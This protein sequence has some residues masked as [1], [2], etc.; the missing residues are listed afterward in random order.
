MTTPTNIVLTESKDMLIV[1][2][3]QEAEH[4]LPAEY[5]RVFS[6]SAEVR[7]HGKGQ[8][9]LQYGKRQV[10]IQ[11]IQQAGNYAIQIT[12]NDGHDSGIFT[13]D[14]LYELGE[15][16]TDNWIS[17]LGRLHE[18]GQSREAGVQVVNLT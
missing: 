17:Y 6:P 12:F 13:W 15:G 16:Y 3:D 2:Y 5:L 14:Y 10:L 7:G 18:A 8:E 4:H 9:V 1:K 11:G